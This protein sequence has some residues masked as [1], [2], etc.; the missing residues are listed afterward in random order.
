MRV[1]STIILL[2]C[3]N[4]IISQRA[5]PHNSIHG[6]TKDSLRIHVKNE[7]GEKS[8]LSEHMPKGTIYLVS[9]WATW[10]GSCRGELKTMQKVHCDWLEEYDFEFLAV[11]IDTPT[12]HPKIFNMANKMNWDF[13]IL[14]DEYGY[15]VKELG[16]SLLPRVF[17]VDQKGNIVY[18][19]KGYSPK[20]LNKLK[21]RIK[22]LSAS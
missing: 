3:F 9:V 13:K 7:A 21:E 14:H 4:T 11:S 17:L 10:C 2:L 16:V 1:I 5:F 19:P 15:L 20:A 8:F 12:D 6:S 18:E 22:T